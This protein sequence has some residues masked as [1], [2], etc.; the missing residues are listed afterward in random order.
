LHDGGS[1]GDVNEGSITNDQPDAERGIVPRR[2]T[3]LGGGGARVNGE[4][5]RRERRGRRGREE[6]GRG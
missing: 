5:G 3:S 4:T 2:R 6:G 1:D